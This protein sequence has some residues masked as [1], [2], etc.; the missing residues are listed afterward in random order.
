MK[1]TLA[2]LG[3]APLPPYIKRSVFTATLSRVRPIA[4]TASTT[5]VGLLPMAFSR[6]E[7]S[8]LWAPM[9]LIVLGGMTSSTIF[10]S[11][12]APCTYLL[13]EDIKGFLSRAMISFG[14]FH[15]SKRE[16]S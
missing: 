3:Q 9:A 2:R 5:I 8:S 16:V 6:S 12:V 15:R 1:K 4:M 10:T 11:L 14:R 7:E 13:L